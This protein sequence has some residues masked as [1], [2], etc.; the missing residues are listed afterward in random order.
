MRIK[1]ALMI[2]ALPAEPCWGWL[3]FIPEQIHPAR[4]CKDVSAQRKTRPLNLQL[5]PREQKTLSGCKPQLLRQKQ[6]GKREAAGE[7]EPQLHEHTSYPHV[8]LAGNETQTA[9][10]FGWRGL[11]EAGNE[12]K[13]A[14]G[15]EHSRALSHPFQSA[16]QLS[17][18]FLYSLPRRRSCQGWTPSA[19]MRSSSPL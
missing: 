16:P 8:H 7:Q 5:Y 12:I 14:K 18:I 17:G 1:G 9:L 10:L 2:F 19:I 3:H 13:W 15:S 11:G 6:P 4:R